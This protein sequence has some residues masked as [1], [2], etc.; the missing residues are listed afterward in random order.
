LRP[1]LYACITEKIVFSRLSY[2]VQ[3]DIAHL[4]IAREIALLRPSSRVGQYNGIPI[5]LRPG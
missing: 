2:D 4:H 5:R 3:L 1:E